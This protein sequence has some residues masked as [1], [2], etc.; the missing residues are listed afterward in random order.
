MRGI[1]PPESRID[2]PSRRVFEYN[3]IGRKTVAILSICWLGG[4]PPLA[5]GV[6]VGWGVPRFSL[7]FYKTGPRASETWNCRQVDLRNVKLSSSGRPKRETVV[8]WT[9]EVWNSRH[10]CGL[11]RPKCETVVKKLVGQGRQL[12]LITVNLIKS[13]WILS[14]FN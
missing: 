14:N 13:D 8:K 5:N 6:Y 12:N 7:F 4:A 1:A 3:K 2:L 11:G 10:F 9:S